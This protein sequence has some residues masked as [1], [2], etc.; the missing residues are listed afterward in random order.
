MTKFIEVSIQVGE[1]DKND[2]VIKTSKPYGFILDTKIGFKNIGAYI[3]ELF[4]EVWK[5]EL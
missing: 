3:E 4:N 5:E 1:C 2:T